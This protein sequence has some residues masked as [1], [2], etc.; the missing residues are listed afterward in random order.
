MNSLLF[1]GKTWAVVIKAHFS[2]GAFPVRIVAQGP[3]YNSLLNL[4]RMINSTRHILVT[5]STAVL[6]TSMSSLNISARSSSDGTPFVL[7]DDIHVNQI[8]V[9]PSQLKQVIIAGELR[10]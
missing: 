8:G 6:V 2:R 4:K 3:C 10:G 1:L 7:D 9:Q 5:I